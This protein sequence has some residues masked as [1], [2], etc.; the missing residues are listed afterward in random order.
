MEDTVDI[1]EFASTEEWVRWLSDNHSNSPGV[2][3]RLAKKSCPKPMLAHPEALDAALCHGWIDAQKRGESEATWLQRF[4]PR[5]KKSLWSKINCT[6]ALAL[7]DSGKMQPAGIREVERA[8][9]DGR[10]DAAY[11]SFR[12][13]EVSDDLQAA[14]NASPKAQAFFKTLNSTNRYSVLWRVQTAKTAATR[15]KRI[16][17]MIEMLEAGKMFHP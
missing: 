17:Q 4:T 13:A 8:K 12:T 5:A 15:S 1:L 7:I 9:A 3:V 6:K 10:W 14:L 16:A 2:W 11:D